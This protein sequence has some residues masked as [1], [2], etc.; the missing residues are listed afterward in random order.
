MCDRVASISISFR[1]GRIANPSYGKVFAALEF[2][3][4]RECTQDGIN[5]LFDVSLN[6]LALCSFPQLHGLLR[7]NHG[8]DHAS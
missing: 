6:S 8:T 5:H 7:F 3:L 4:L 1:D 2:D